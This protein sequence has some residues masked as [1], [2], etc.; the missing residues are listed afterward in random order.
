MKIRT[1][2]V[3]NS[4]SSSFIVIFETKEDFHNKRNVAF[5]DCQGANYADRINEDIECNK[6]TR[7]EVLNTIKE[8]II[9]SVEWY[10]MWKHPKISEMDVHEFMK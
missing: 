4:S 9:Q 3:T 2:F 5:E 8:N 1:D 10:L 7:Q 6:V